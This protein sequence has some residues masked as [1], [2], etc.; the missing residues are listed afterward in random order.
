MRLRWVFIPDQIAVV[1]IALFAEHVMRM[2]LFAWYC[3]ANGPIRITCY[4]NRFVFA[5]LVIPI[6]ISLRNTSNDPRYI[7]PWYMFITDKSYY[8]DLR[9]PSYGQ[10]QM[11][12]TALT[13]SPLFIAGKSLAHQFRDSIFL[14]TIFDLRSSIVKIEIQTPPCCQLGDC[15]R[16]LWYVFAQSWST[17]SNH[18]MGLDL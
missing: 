10:T 7:V 8:I 3:Y 15:L 2:G 12:F 1:R 16:L 17:S 11:Q 13:N 5:Q 9:Y 18:T 14:F 6:I 4:A